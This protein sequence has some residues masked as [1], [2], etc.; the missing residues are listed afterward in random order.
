[1][2]S[3]ARRAGPEGASVKSIRDTPHSLSLSFLQSIEDYS[4][5]VTGEQFIQSEDGTQIYV[6]QFQATKPKA[7][8]LL[9]H[10]YLEHC[11]R[12]CEFAEYL[13]SEHS[14]SVLTYDFRGHGKSGGTRPVLKKWKEYE[15]DFEAVRC[16]L[17]PSL[18]TFILGHSNGGLT[19]LNY[20][21]GRSADDPQVKNLKGVIVTNPYVEATDAVPWFVLGVVHT[22]GRWFP[23]LKVP[24]NLKGE[25]LTS[26]P[27]LQKDHDED[28]MNQP[29]ASIG[30]ASQALKKQ[31]RVKKLAGTSEFPLPILYVYS[32]HD[33]VANPKALEVVGEQLQA[34]DKTVVR[35]E[36]EQ[37]EVLNETN[38]QELYKII[39]EW[40]IAHV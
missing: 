13:N 32:T 35:R 10:G 27:V 39:G 23:G 30:W 14:I 28:E 26:D 15:Q 40:I 17:Q 34:K 37:H 22:L 24:S 7:Q 31:D 21:L 9:L 2:M 1:M 11:N 8:V 38:R 5:M 16:T 25:D 36:G 19:A 4:T 29:D 33:K 12:Y 18:P 20:F 6:K 3:M